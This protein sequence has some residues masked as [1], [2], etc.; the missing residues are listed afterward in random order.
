MIQSLLEQEDLTLY[1]MCS[2]DDLNGDLKPGRRFAQ[3]QCRLDI[4][5]YGCM[6]D[7]K[8]WGDWFQQCEIYLQD[9]LVCHQNTRYYNPHKLSS[10][11]LDS[12]PMVAEV[13][14]QSSSQIH[15]QDIQDGIDMLDLL[16][17]RQDLEEAQQPSAIKS[18]L[19]RHQKQALTFMHHR[20]QGWGSN[21]GQPDIW[22]IHDKAEQRLFYNMVSET[23]QQEEPPQFYGGIIADPMGL[24][25]TLTMIALA[26]SDLEKEYLATRFMTNEIE[27]PF[28]SAT[29]VVVPPPLLGSWEE[30]LIG[31]VKTGQLSYRCH[32]GKTKFTNSSAVGNFRVVLTTYHT[33]S[34]EWKIG[35]ATDNSVLFDVRWR[36]IILDEAHYIRNENSQMAQA[37]CALDA[38]SRWAVTGTPIQ[39]R[40]SDLATLV[41]FIRVHPYTDT[42]QFDTDL[43]RLWKSGEDEK[44][45]QRLQYLSSCLLLRR[46]KT[47]IN[48]PSRHDKLC[49]VDFTKDERMVYDQMRQQAIQSIETALQSD[50]GSEAPKVGTYYV[51][52]LQQIE[53]LRLF[54]NLG[55][56]YQTRHEKPKVDGPSWS[57]IAQQCFNMERQRGVMICFCCSSVL[58]LTETI[59]DDS[60]TTTHLP[61]L[62]QCL[63]FACGECSKIHS[64]ARQ[65]LAC[66]H[67]PTCS[68]APVSLGSNTLENIPHMTSFE[69][70]SRAPAVVSSKV[71]AL[72]ADI[73]SL[74]PGVKSIVFSSWRLTLDVV[75]KALQQAGIR[76]LR[77]DG[78]VPQKERQSVV[79]TFRSD[80]TVSVMLLTLSCGAVGL[81]LTEA[82]RAYLM[83][84]H[85]NPNIEEQALA[86]VH[87]IGQTQEVTT[88]RMYMRDSFEKQVM[89]VQDTKKQL[90]GVLLSPHDGGRLDDKLGS[91]QKLR[92][93][94]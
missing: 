87:R 64:E 92:S 13:I 69:T 48:L 90:A 4:T 18:Q 47:T 22:V 15:F 61:Q 45:V 43:S 8:Q 19:Q 12:C 40:L 54:C 27:G 68:M 31:H 28:A 7:S 65:R 3:V 76:S 71:K 2:V 75:Q 39:N 77:F 34:S 50:S 67:N 21:P 51:N 58:E 11:I 89:E 78:K 42:R 14:E 32:H 1:P 72:V 49:A 85:W 25:K 52:V 93:L 23:H 59:L 9:P 80:P 26:A 29:L 10:D 46:P 66:D 86:R 38:H 41:K 73:K 63:K 70:G 60:E 36:R 74:A 33:V 57:D 83:E 79:E 88:V 82:S 5:I 17:S 30:Q 6:A 37:V 81:T 20:E 56:G 62:F 44:A 94:L 53:S 24:G 84:P 16:S 55:L 35:M 91:L